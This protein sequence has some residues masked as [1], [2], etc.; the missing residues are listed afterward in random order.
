[1]PADDIPRND[2]NGTLNGRERQ[3][4]SV[5]SFLFISFVL[6]MLTN[7]SGDEF[8][9]RHQYQDALRSLSYQLSNFTAWRNGT[10]SDFSLPS[11]DITAQPLVDSFLHYG[12]LQDPSRASY[13]P[14]ITGFLRGEGSAHNITLLS[15]ASET[16]PWKS[17]AVEYTS[18]LNITEASE[19]AGSWNWT[20]S[21]KVALSLVEK[22]TVDPQTGQRLRLSDDVALAHGRIEFTDVNTADELRLEF[23]AIHFITNGSFYGFAL[24]NGR[25]ID[26]RLLPSLVPDPHKNATADMIKPEIEARIKKLQQLIDDGNIV[27][28]PDAPNPDE[29]IKTNCSFT[30]QAHLVPSKVPQ[31]LM[32]ELEEEIQKPTGVSTVDPPRIAVDALFLSKDC[33]ILYEIHEAEGLRSRTFFRKVTTY[34]AT[35]GIVYLILLFLLIRQMEISRTPSGI[36]RVSR[37]TLLFQATMD[38]LS[39]A[40]H[41]TFA[42][43]FDGRASLSLVAPAFLACTLF[44]HE[45]QFAILVYQVQLPEDSVPTPQPTPTIPPVS[46]N[47]PIEPASPGINPPPSVGPQPQPTTAAATATAETSSLLLFWRFITSDPQ[48][49]VWFA[50]FLFVIVLV[51]VI[52]SPVMGV[53][54]VA[55]SY[56]SIWMPQ[57][58]RSAR[59]GRASGLSKEYLLGTSACRV[60]LMLYFLVCPKNVLEVQPRRWTWLLAL[61]VFA[62][63]GVVLLQDRFGPDFF[64]PARFK[65]VNVYDYHP[66]LPVPDAEAP[67]QSLGDCAICMDAIVIDSSLRRRSEDKLERQMSSSKS[68][69]KAR[70]SG[71]LNAMQKR[72]VGGGAKARKS[73]SLAPC[74]HL[75]HTE[76][77]EKWLAIKVS[78]IPDGTQVLTWSSIEYMPTMSKTSTTAMTLSCILL[79]R[80]LIGYAMVKPPVFSPAMSLDKNLFTLVVTP[81]KDHPN[82]VDLVEPSGTI[83]YRK[84]RVVDPAGYKVEVYDPMS[85]SLLVTV[86]APASTSKVKVLELCN[87]TKIVELKYTGT[88]SFKWSFQWEEHEFEWKREECYLLRKPDPPVLVAVTKEPAGRLKTSSIQVLDYNLNR[89]DIDDRKGL[90][91][92]MLTALL[93]FHDANDTYHKDG[94]PPSAT[95]FFGVRRTTSEATVAESSAA[96]QSAP[97]T[98][99][100]KPTPRGGIDR[101]AEMQAIQGEYNEV[102]VTEEGSIEDYGQYCFNLLQDDAILFITI[103]SAGAEQV[104]KVVQVVE[105]TKRVRHKAGV[106]EEIHQYVLY[107]T[108]ASPQKGPR[109]I[110][111]DGD[112]DKTKSKYTPPNSLTIH[113]SKIP[114]PELQPKA[115]VPEKS[116]KDLKKEEKERKDKEKKDLKE[117]E[118]KD[119]DKEK[120]KEKKDHREGPKANTPPSTPGPSTEASPP[121]RPNKLTRPGQPHSSSSRVETPSAA[122]LSHPS[123]PSRYSMQPPPRPSSSPAPPPN[124]NGSYAQ[125]FYGAYAPPPRPPQSG[126]T[127]NY[128]NTSHIPSPANK[129]SGHP[130]PPP[131]NQYN[132]PGGQSVQNGAITPSNVVSGLLGL[133]NRR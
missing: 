43:L 70:T 117:K 49:R 130:P 75:F 83:H 63:V 32:A 57:I 111:L 97:P 126:Y 14:N 18:D 44:I 128:P 98:L 127:Q 5:P 115:A 47:P 81:N 55:F 107:D 67:E 46:N 40:G 113:I 69:V 38:S 51:R 110:K 114:M 20:A 84:Q 65:Q 9:A 31:Y 118:R 92:V 24:P 124:V 119:K 6:F 112:D 52:L 26:I 50:L 53:L 109:R 73:Y 93:T 37:W 56:S 104:P 116:A 10:E 39:F 68:N 33:G 77:L 125:S 8:L 87:P 3:R 85:E 101:I 34:A 7:H 131:P 28:D 86:T 103:R 21:D 94:E 80:P 122:S 100:P 23:E 11:T 45:A 129:W 13:H 4:G 99:P 72:M 48:I 60:Y 78:C 64:L 132:Q 41:I 42:I 17:L 1:M 120:K 61:F 19:R 12:Q 71:F 66:V 96:G 123:K 88:L 105:Q 30:F 2:D 90:E 22:P 106:E 91:I 133:L 29:G 89:F 54:Y 79:H 15:L 76:C 35:A 102:T 95:S 62:Q 58:I 36:A 108:I 74:H 82:V 16:V 121:P 25:Q 27:I 59:R